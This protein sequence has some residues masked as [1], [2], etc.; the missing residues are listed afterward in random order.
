LGYR[1]LVGAD[2]NPGLL[3]MPYNNSIRYE[4]CD[5]MHTKFADSSFQVITS[6]SVIEHGFDDLSLLRESS[7]LLKPGGYFIASFDYWP[8]K[9]DTFDTKLFGMD[10]M[11][12]SR[13][14]IEGLIAK[15]NAYGLSPVGEM[16]YDR[17]DALIEF[18]GRN[19]TFAWLALQKRG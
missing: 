8:D 13:E 9:I 2:L 7:R 1:N 14:D 6:I 18:E 19:Y 16:R 17:K 4:I 12:F 11:I 10:W 5:F 15:A 3:E